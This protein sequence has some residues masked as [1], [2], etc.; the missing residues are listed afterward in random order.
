[1]L[2]NADGS[3]QH[4]LLPGDTIGFVPGL[5]GPRKARIDSH[6]TVEGCITPRR[7]SRPRIGRERPCEQ[8]AHSTADAAD[9]ILL[10]SNERQPDT[11]SPPIR[12]TTWPFTGGC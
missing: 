5:A 12:V 4:Q 2:M 9:Q 1:M 7:S 10:R 11:L 6:M 8:D 3:N